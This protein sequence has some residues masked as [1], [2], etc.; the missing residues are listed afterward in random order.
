ML[1]VVLSPGNFL[2]WILVGLIAGAVAGRLTRGRGYGCIGDIIVGLI[3]AVV[4]GYIVSLFVGNATHTYGF[5]A[6]TLVAILGAV[7]LLVL[8]RL[9]R[10]AL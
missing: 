3:G 5:L 8:L 6:T 1:L 9:I 7:V 2:A 4:G 10:T